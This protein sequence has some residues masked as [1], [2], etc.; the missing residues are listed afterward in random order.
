MKRASSRAAWK[1]TR[2]WE[3]RWRKWSGTSTF[4]LRTTFAEIKRF[5]SHCVPAG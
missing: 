2:K 3:A 4:A 5:S 1:Q